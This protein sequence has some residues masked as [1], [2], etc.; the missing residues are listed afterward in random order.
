MEFG[1]LIL[2]IISIIFLSVT[3][4]ILTIP[5][6]KGRRRTIVKREEPSE[7]YG[8]TAGYLM[9]T[10]KSKSIGNMLTKNTIPFINL[11]AILFIASFFSANPILL[12]ASLLPL[13]AFLLGIFIENPRTIKITRTG[14]RNSVWIGEILEV[15][16]NV[17]IE[18]GIGFVTV[19]D[20]IPEVFSLVE[21][22]N[23]KIFWKGF[24][25]ASYTFSYKIRC[26][27]RGH[28][29]FPPVKWE[30]RH[31]LLLKETLYGE[32]G[33][34]FELT[35]RPRIYNVRRLRGRYTTSIL[36]FPQRSYVKIGPSSTDFR[37]IRDYT[38]G[39]P[40]KSINWKA[41][42]RYLWRRRFTPLVNEYERE[43]QQ[44]IWIFLNGSKNLE[45]GTSIENPL[46]YGIAAAMSLS[47]YFLRRGYRLGMYIY[48][49]RGEIFYPDTGMR[50]V[51]RL[52]RKLSHL[53]VLIREEGLAEAVQKNRKFLMQYNPLCI[54]ITCLRGEKPSELMKGLKTLVSL[55][56]SRR[57]KPPI[58]L[59]NVLP[60]D[61]LSRGNPYDE[62]SKILLQLSDRPLVNTLRRAGVSVLEWNPLSE[63][64]SMKLLRQ[65]K[66]G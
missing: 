22:S 51:F 8:V 32:S 45:I 14:L 38:I 4:V 36:P 23:I 34:W 6:R 28:F 21:G 11:F 53:E 40:V 30:S 60:Q 2:L 48:N 35:V 15:T 16:I 46:E 26:P 56:K 3:V 7:K 52:M 33:Y 47:Y 62:N 9:S 37:E 19:F 29:F 1:L 50:Q 63:E 42:A 17:E 43:G 25:K 5:D 64:F 31:A 66:R 65:V 59:I 41:T 44:T 54:I 13:F 49:G 20:R 57:K 10:A 61:M 39:D 24:K 27:K 18:D 55:K 58:L 12:G